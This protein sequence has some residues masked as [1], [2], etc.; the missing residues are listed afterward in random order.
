MSFKLRDYQQDAVDAFFESVK[1]GGRSGVIS[2]P[3]GSG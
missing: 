1:N 2:A 3:T